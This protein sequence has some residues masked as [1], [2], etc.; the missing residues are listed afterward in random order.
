VER[1]IHR[2]P[3][4]ATK[5][6]GYEITTVC[7]RTEKLIQDGLISSSM[8]SLRQAW[9]G[10]DAKRLVAIRY[11]SLTADTASVIAWK[12]GFWRKMAASSVEPERGSPEII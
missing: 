3:L 12:A 4:L 6:F 7:Q 9:F 1:A 8:G 2:N 5:I 10:E 11:D